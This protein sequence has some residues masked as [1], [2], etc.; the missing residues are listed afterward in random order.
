MLSKMPS[1][2]YTMIGMCNMHNSC[3]HY[4]EDMCW[5]WVVVRVEPIMLIF[6]PVILFCNSCNPSLLFLLHAPIIP[7]NFFQINFHMKTYTH[8]NLFTDI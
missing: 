5:A 4:L 3:L 2:S 8:N 1:L 6:I 7:I